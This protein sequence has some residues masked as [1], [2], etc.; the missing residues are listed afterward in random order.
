MGEIRD[1]V[2]RFPQRELDIRRRAARDSRFRALCRDY[3]EAT[4][5]LRHWREVADRG[6]DPGGQIAC[7]YAVFVGELEG[8]ILATLD[9]PAAA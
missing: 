3:G 5:A 1:I 6:H 9:A 7:E 8:E 2:A 4:A